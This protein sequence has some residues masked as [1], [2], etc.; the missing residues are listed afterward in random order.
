MMALSVHQFHEILGYLWSKLSC[1]GDNFVL[2]T[3]T[4]S[5]VG[6]TIGIVWGGNWRCFLGFR[7]NASIC[8]INM[9][10]TLSLSSHLTVTMM[11]LC[12]R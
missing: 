12:I 4:F 2:S 3:N 9:C 8:D 6:G 1:L 5:E 11:A 7:S 10:E